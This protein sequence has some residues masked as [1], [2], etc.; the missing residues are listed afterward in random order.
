MAVIEL[1]SLWGE[2]ADE[3][4]AQCRDSQGT[5]HNPV[6][7]TCLLPMCNR[8]YRG[9]SRFCNRWSH[10]MR[11]FRSE[12]IAGRKASAKKRQGAKASQR[13]SWAGPHV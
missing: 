3:W 4:Q 5:S 9:E 2:V 7:R 10:A 1:G 12:A 6:Q 13:K 11:W 8:S